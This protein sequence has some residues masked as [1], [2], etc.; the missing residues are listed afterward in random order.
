M[1]TAEGI[2][3]GFEEGNQK[4][5]EIKNAIFDGGFVLSIK[6]RADFGNANTLNILLF[7]AVGRVKL[8]IDRIHCYAFTHGR[9]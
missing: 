6:M 2:S 5:T 7:P 4:Y 8:G 1:E 3:G 9:K